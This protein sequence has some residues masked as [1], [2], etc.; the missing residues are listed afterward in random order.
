MTYLERDDMARPPAYD[1]FAKLRAE[2]NRAEHELLVAVR[3][4]CPGPHRPTQHRDGKRPWCKSC[5]RDS[6]GNQIKAVLDL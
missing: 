3:D 4:A 6:L 1:P 5:G 2:L